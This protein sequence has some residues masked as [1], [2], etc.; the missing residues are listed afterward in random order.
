MNNC[1]RNKKTKKKKELYHICLVGI[2]PF[3]Y[4]H[5]LRILVIKKMNLI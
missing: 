5:G 3:I 4:V 1:Y 2:T